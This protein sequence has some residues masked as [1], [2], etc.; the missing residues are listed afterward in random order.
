MQSKCRTSRNIIPRINPTTDTMKKLIALLFTFTLSLR[1]IAADTPFTC[2]IAAENTSVIQGKIPQVKVSIA[3]NS[4]KVVHLVR[5]LDGSDSGMRF[6]KCG[7]EILDTAGKPVPE[8]RRMGRCGN[9]NLLQTTDFVKVTVG[10]EFN[11]S[12]GEF[13]FSAQLDRFLQLPPG[14]YILRFYY[15]TSTKGVEDYFGDERQMRG[16]TVAPE[17]QKLFEGVPLIDI[18]SNDLKITVKA[19]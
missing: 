10:S 2:S 7:I 17:M 16:M 4:G 1:V 6:P 14:I 18:K 12:K 15:Q 13:F 11:P 8:K 3:N 9:M 19:K 5:S